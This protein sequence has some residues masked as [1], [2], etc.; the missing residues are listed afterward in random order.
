MFKK[1]FG[2]LMAVILGV[3]MMVGCS[4]GKENTQTAPAEKGEVQKAPQNAK[5][6]ASEKIEIKFA[7]ADN[8]KSI[9]HKG[10]LA[11]KEKVE[12]L[13]G[14]SMSVRIFPSGQLGTLSDT[15]QG[16]QMGTIDVAPI[17][18]TVLANFSPSIAVYDLPF[19]IEN[20]KHAYASL[21]GEVG[22]V[23]EKEL[24]GQ[25]MLAKGWWTLGFRNAT[26]S[27]DVKSIDDLAGQK[28]RTQNSQIHLAIFKALGVDPT[29]MDFSEL[30]TALQ[31]KTVDGQENPYVN[32]LQANIFEV[33]NTIVE[34]EHVFQVAG[35]LV[36]P[37]LWDKLTDEQRNVIDKASEYATG[38]ERTACETENEKAKEVLQK[39]HGM[40][41]VAVDKAELQKRTASVYDA[42]PQL[43]ELVKKVKSYK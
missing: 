11:F 13:S 17:S 42:Y 9:F 41:V 26:T 10:A 14:G 25:S 6:D 38:I 20:Y 35:L 33:N 23:L 39:E 19:I 43:A 15:A 12:E 18:A 5:T 22:D 37:T 36:S 21:D 32:I 4:S 29:P 30:F 3:Y 40:K 27:K 7:H 24:E 34:T 8:E 1:M 16:I 28:I 31:Q 2:L